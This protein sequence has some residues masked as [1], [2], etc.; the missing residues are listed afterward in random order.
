LVVGNTVVITGNTAGAGD[1]GNKKESAPEDVRGYD[2][3]TGK[4]LWTFHVVPR[5]GEFGTDT[6]GNESWKVA[7][8]LGAWNPMTGD[9]QLGLVYIPL[10]APTAAAFGGWRPGSNLYSNALVALDPKSGK[11]ARHFPIVH[12]D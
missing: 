5:A 4:L 1:G 9:E 6:W 7:G 2:A 8:D 11:R 12:P 10:T 3:Q